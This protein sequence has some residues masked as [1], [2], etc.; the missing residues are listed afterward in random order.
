MLVCINDRKANGV[1]KTPIIA[2]LNRRKV[3]ARHLIFDDPD[4]YFAS[5]C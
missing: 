3:A 4:L 5:T 1:M 2:Q